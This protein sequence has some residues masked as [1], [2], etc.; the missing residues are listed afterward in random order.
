MSDPV[1]G[2][3]GSPS[4][5]SGGGGRGALVPGPGGLTFGVPSPPK[6]NSEIFFE[7]FFSK[8]KGFLGTSTWKCSG[9]EPRSEP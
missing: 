9:S 6:K 5:R 3:V 8:K 2:L 4:P 1:S 7:F